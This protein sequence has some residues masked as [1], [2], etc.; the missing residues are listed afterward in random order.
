MRQ[1]DVASIIDIIEAA[2]LAVRFVADT[3][4]ETFDENLMMQSAVIR[5]LEIMEEAAK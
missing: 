5:Q 1:R 4:R 2:R 3:T